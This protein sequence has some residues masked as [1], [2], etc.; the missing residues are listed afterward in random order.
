MKDFNRFM[1]NKTEHH[2]KK[3]FCWYFLQYF[4]TSRVLQCYL[5]ICLAINHTKSVSLPEE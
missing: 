3:P 2:V 5:K 4:S 1:T